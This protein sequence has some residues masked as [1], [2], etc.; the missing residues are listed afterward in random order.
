VQTGVGRTGTPL[1]Y[2]H[3]DVVPD[4]VTL[5]KGLGG[6]FP[7]AAFACTDAVASTVQIGDHGTTFGGNPLACAAASAVLRVVEREKLA[8]RAARLG[9]ELMRRLREFAAARPDLVETVRGRGLLV[10]LVLRDAERAATIPG[11]ALERGVVVNVTAGRVVRFFPA[12]NIP[13]DELWEALDVV[14][15]LAAA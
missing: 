8:E 1:G 15:E 11:R 6:G 9:T 14:L 7:V 10:G 2:Q 4:V 5:G 3:E 12:L 13:E